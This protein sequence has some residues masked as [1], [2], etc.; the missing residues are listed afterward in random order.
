VASPAKRQRLSHDFAPK[1]KKTVVGGSLQIMVINVAGST[2]KTTF[3]KHGLVPL[4][5]NALRISIEDW[6]T[7]DGIS[8][9]EIGSKSFHKL[10]VQLNVDEEQSF[11]MDVGTSNSRG[12][13]KHLSELELTRD[14]ID[15]YVCPIRTGAKESLDTLKTI[16]MLLQMGISPKKIVVIAQAVTDTDTFSQDFATI[17][18]ASKDAGFHFASQPVLFN[19]IYDLLKN[20]DRTVFDVVKDKPDFAGLRTQHRGDQTKLLEIGHEML[21]YSLSA[22]ACRNLRAVFDCTPLSS[23]FT[24]EVIL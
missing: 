16:S 23:S 3:T 13:L 6:N 21:L 18:E 15:C 11:V 10:A 20:S 7:G 22:A 1:F 5:A 4:I 17:I 24:S 12:I 14:E 19:E 2:A 8:D 9:L